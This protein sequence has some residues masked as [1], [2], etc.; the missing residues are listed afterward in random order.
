MSQLTLILSQ[1]QHQILLTKATIC[2]AYSML[3]E[4]NDI[5]ENTPQLTIINKTVDLVDVI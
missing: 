3:L 1:F 4:I 5:K 2:L